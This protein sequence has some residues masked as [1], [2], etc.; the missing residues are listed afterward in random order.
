MF[1]QRGNFE[2]RMKKIN[3]VTSLPPPKQPK[4]SIVFSLM[5]QKK[6]DKSVTT[7][8]KLYF[9]TCVQLY[10]KRRTPILLKRSYQLLLHDS[11]YKIENF[12]GLSTEDYLSNN[13]GNQQLSVAYNKK[14]S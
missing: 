2:S 6:K 5:F 10:E 9:Y 4:T 13:F 8:C 11:E 3:N 7:L 12:D 14:V 1:L